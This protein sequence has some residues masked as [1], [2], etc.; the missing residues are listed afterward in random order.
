MPS[1][2]QE[3]GWTPDKH[4]T[5]AD[6]SR[7]AAGLIQHNDQGENTQ[8][9]VGTGCLPCLSAGVR[10][11]PSNERCLLFRSDEWRSNDQVANHG[12]I[13]RQ[14][15]TA[16]N[17]WKNYLSRELSVAWQRRDWR[18]RHSLG[19]FISC[20]VPQLSGPF[21]SEFWQRAVVQASYHEPIVLH[22]II[23]LGALH[24]EMLRPRE[25]SR[26]SL[27]A[28]A[29]QQCN[30]AISPLV[31]KLES[32]LCRTDERVIITA[33]VLLATIELL[34]ARLEDFAAHLK[35]ARKL[36]WRCQ[37]TTGSEESSSVITLSALKPVI[38]RLGTQEK[39]RH[40]PNIDP[41][42]YR[43]CISLPNRIRR[44]R[45][46][47]EAYT[48]LQSIGFPYML[49][50]QDVVIRMVHNKPAEPESRM[51]SWLLNEWEA[52]FTAYLF[53]HAA[54][55]RREELRLARIL[56]ANHVF[57]SVMASMS[58]ADKLLPE[59]WVKHRAQIETL[60]DL[61][62]AVLEGEGIS[63]STSVVSLSFT[64]SIWDP[65]YMVVRAN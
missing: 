19:F 36:L 43:A 40:D 2:D 6:V 3:K 20:T 9:V 31:A 48:T 61:A 53:D 11:S 55:F 29:L 12:N 51:Y 57:L 28:F 30:L 33:C 65:L 34:Q 41:H 56:K 1:L 16:R 37:Q 17:E 13:R 22:G 15:H 42:I 39:W 18:E 5:D 24:E 23:A 58:V 63:S 38:E 64:M 46:L 49:D 62:T 8:T 26:V 44:I 54:A 60:L 52:A 27:T 50:Q 25:S 4:D 35:Q 32:E 59:S 47:N 14:T 7:T 45:S 10:C 21:H